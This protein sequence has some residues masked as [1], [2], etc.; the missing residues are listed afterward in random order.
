[1]KVSMV[2]AGPIDI[3]AI[4]TMTSA[5]PASS[6]AF[7]QSQ[8]RADVGDKAVSLGSRKIGTITLADLTSRRAAQ[9]ESLRHRGRAQRH[10]Y[11]HLVEFL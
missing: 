6:K 2:S 4:V 1:M 5:M 3:V 8:A 11:S 10:H 9:R 7:S